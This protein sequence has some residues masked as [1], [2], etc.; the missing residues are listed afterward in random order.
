MYPDRKQKHNQVISSF[1][2]YVDKAVKYD[3]VPIFQY[4]TAINDIDN[5][6]HYYNYCMSARQTIILSVAWIR[7]ISRCW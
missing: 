1:I 6:M 3:F 2:V 5:V 4:F 7:T